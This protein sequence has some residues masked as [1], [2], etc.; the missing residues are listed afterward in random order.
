M[1]SVVWGSLTLLAFCTCAVYDLEG[2]GRDGVV[3]YFRKVRSPVNF[4]LHQSA[5]FPRSS[6][7]PDLAAS[8]S[9]T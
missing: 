5:G 4:S 3:K 1:G 8:R 2:P 7:R 9:H 6:K